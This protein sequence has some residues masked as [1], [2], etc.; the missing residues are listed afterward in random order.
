MYPH[1]STRLHI[2]MQYTAGSVMESAAV[3]YGAHLAILRMKS[4]ILCPKEAKQY[5]YL[6]YVE[7]D[8]ILP[9]SKYIRDE[10]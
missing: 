5:L 1:C 8:K 9:K 4:S 10:R 6:F 2:C 7:I 3:K